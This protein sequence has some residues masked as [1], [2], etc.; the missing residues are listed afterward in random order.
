M[1]ASHPDDGQYADPSFGGPD[2]VLEYLSRYTHR[3]A[4][5]NRRLLDIDDDNVK[6]SYRDRRDGNRLKELTIAA[7]E[8]LRRFLLHVTPPGLCRIRHYGF[9]SNRCK[10]E[11]LPHC[12]ALLG[13]APPAIVAAVLT[14]VALILRNT[15]IDVSRCP[16]GKATGRR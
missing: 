2:K 12:R 1:L 10:K 13:Q 16:H 6:F 3:V 14:V 8:F 11:R 4:V 5:S 15:G 7:P 9:L